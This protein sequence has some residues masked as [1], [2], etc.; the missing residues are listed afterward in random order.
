MMTT[1][2]SD[3]LLVIGIITL[4]CTVLSPI[5]VWILPQRSEIAQ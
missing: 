5:L 2:L 3:A 1:D 4:A